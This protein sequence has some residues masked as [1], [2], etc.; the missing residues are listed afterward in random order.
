[1]FKPVTQVHVNTV[2]IKVVPS[3]DIEMCPVLR[4]ITTQMASSISTKA[5]AL[6]SVIACSPFVHIF[7]P[8]RE[9]TTPHKDGT[10]RAAYTCRVPKAGPLTGD[11]KRCSMQLTS[12]NTHFVVPPLSSLQRRQIG[13]VT[14]MLWCKQSVQH[15]TPTCHSTPTSYLLE[16]LLESTWLS[17]RFT[18]TLNISEW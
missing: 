12:S 3:T 10:F 17:H 1:M 11:N 18:T 6:K 2:L 13:V 9:D 4:W 16:L 8:Y 5:N 14:Q 15:I 7:P